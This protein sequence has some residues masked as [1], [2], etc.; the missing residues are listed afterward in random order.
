M[1]F[2]CETEKNAVRVWDYLRDG[3]SNG[4]S[5]IVKNMPAQDIGIVIIVNQNDQ[6]TGAH[7]A[8]AL[9]ALKKRLLVLAAGA[10]TLP[11]TTR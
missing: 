11:A 3:G 8:A 1:A 6:H 9:A 10:V 4:T 2:F 5:T 7:V